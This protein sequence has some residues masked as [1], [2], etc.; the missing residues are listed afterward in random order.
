MGLFVAIRIATEKC[1]PG[2]RACVEVC[3]V[4]VFQVGPESVVCSSEDNEDE[5]NF[6]DLCLSRCPASAIQIVKRY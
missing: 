3:P 2:C 4:D 1:P 5:C 6:C